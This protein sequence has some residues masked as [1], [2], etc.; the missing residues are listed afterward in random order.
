MSRNSEKSQ[1]ERAGY[2]C[3][4]ES[5]RFHKGRSGNPRGRPKNRRRDLPYDHVLGQM[6]TVR[7]DG[8][9]KRVTAAEAFLLYLTKKGL[10]GDGASARASLSAIEAARS[11]RRAAGNEQLT[12]TRIILMTYGPGIALERLGM[13]VKKYGHDKDRARWELKPWV[14]E[15][16]LSRLKS[17]MLTDEQQR[18]IWGATFKPQSVKW[19]EWWSDRA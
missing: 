10:E 7:E 13:G 1:D 9:E 14:V 4:P 17:R 8:H 15:A 12:I 6:V 3:P 2:K 16:A 19:P 11:M 5:G 18:E